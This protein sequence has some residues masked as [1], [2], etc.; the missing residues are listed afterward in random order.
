MASGL[1]GTYLFP[2]PLQT[3]PVDVA[4]DVQALA[5]GIETT[6]LLKAPLAS[7]ALTGVPTAPT[8][9]NADSSTTLATTA[10]VK[11]QAYLTVA[12][13]S[14][15][16]APIASPTFT[17]TVTT[18][19]ETFVGASAGYG[20]LKNTDAYHAIL[21]NGTTGSSI[22][23][24][25]T[26]GANISEFI[27]YG[28]TWHFKQIT[29]VA[30]T[31][32]L[33]I[34]PTASTF[35][36][37]IVSAAATASL[38]SLRIPHGTAPSSPTNG[39]VWTTTIGMYA[40]INGNTVGPFGTGA[41]Y[42]GTAPTAITGA[43]WAD[44]NYNSL[45]VYTGTRWASMT[46]TVVQSKTANYTLALG[47]EGS[48][49]VMSGGTTNSITIP[50]NASVALPIGSSVMIAQTSA[51]QTVISGAGVTLYATPGLKLRTQYSVA[52][53]LKVGTDA[54]VITGDLVA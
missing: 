47:D 21:L 49:L 29:G 54:W 17:G 18:T 46:G 9:N 52:T 39:D 43:L 34:T 2:Y 37:T 40:R 25:V 44:S 27:E 28:G 53:L 45:T 4:A 38:P 36:G 19:A 16:F 33:T 11:N 31:T 22:T 32:V 7:P 26:P 20:R 41:T 10:F 48:I 1:T 51:I 3:D 30:N 14:T 35:T 12:T 50:T 23:A 42:T 6:M 15:T 24:A 8:P 5:Q 13:A